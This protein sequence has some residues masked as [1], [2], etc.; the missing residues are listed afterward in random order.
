MISFSGDESFVCSI[1]SALIKIRAFQ[2]GPFIHFINSPYLC[3]IKLNGDKLI[4]AYRVVHTMRNRWL[5]ITYESIHEWMNI[6]HRAHRYT[7]HK[8]LNCIEP[9][10][11]WIPCDSSRPNFIVIFRFFRFFPIS[12]G[13]HKR[14]NQFC[15]VRSVVILFCCVSQESSHPFIKY[16]LIFYCN[17]F[18]V[19]NLIL[20][21]HGS[22][23]SSNRSNVFVVGV[24]P[25]SRQWLN[26]WMAYISFFHLETHK[27]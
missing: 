25:S 11:N 23:V 3:E 18:N 6:N 4:G 5:A 20:A 1:E 15:I 26:N 2:F 9:M 19:E 13:E 17:L 16:A 14:S 21:H 22:I 8:I 24:Q 10:I 27:T 12:L 7:L